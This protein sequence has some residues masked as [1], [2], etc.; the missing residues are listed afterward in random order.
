MIL[1][2]SHLE[3]IPW[4]VLSTYW[5]ADFIITTLYW[6]CKKIFTW[7]SERL[8]HFSC[9]SK[10][11]YWIAFHVPLLNFLKTKVASIQARWKIIAWVH[12]H[13][14]YLRNVCIS[15]RKL[16]ERMCRRELCSTEIC[17]KTWIKWSNLNQMIRGVE[18]WR[19]IDLLDLVVTSIFF[20]KPLKFVVF[21]TFYWRFG[22]S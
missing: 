3:R 12:R 15:F 6:T 11:F 1:F 16:C 21:T 19:L 20:L 9:N 5:I 4:V 10:R 14:T 18:K 17:R 2:F 7:L 8:S 13:P 22:C